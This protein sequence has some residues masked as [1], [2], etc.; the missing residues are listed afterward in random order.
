MTHEDDRRLLTSIPYKK[1]ELKIIVAKKDCTLGNHY[2]KIKEEDFT[3]LEG[4]A[5]CTIED[6]QFDMSIDPKRVFVGQNKKHSFDIKKDSILFCVC[7]HPYDKN[8]D[9]EN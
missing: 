6:Q 1:G 9:Y 3:L 7:S 8:D 5:I 2:H 4:N